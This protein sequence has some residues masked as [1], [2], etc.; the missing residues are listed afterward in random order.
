MHRAVHCWTLDR[1]GFLS[2]YFNTPG[3]IFLNYC[4]YYFDTFNE[5]ISGKTR[6]PTAVSLCFLRATLAVQIPLNLNLKKQSCVGTRVLLIF[7]HDHPVR[8]PI[9]FRVKLKI[10]MKI[11]F[12]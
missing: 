5:T 11:Q 7:K 10:M 2:D 6:R 4:Y 3:T 12:L 8:F 1:V 9:R